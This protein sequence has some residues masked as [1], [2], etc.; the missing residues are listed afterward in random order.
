MSSFLFAFYLLLFLLAVDLNNCSSPFLDPVLY[1]TKY[2][3]LDDTHTARS[4]TLS[5]YI[6]QPASE[7]AVLDRA[8]RKFQKFVH[9]N[10]TGKL[11]AAT[12]HQMSLSRCGNPDIVDRRKATALQSFKFK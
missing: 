6:M 4:I 8:I 1:L 10:E 5:S 11:D 9:L 7:S 2:G 12:L 3:Y